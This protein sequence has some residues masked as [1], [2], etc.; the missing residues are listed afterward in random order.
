M[1]WAWEDSRTFLTSFEAD[2]EECNEVE[3]QKHR[4]E[5][6][7]QEREGP[8]TS[9]LPL[10][11]S[12]RAGSH[13]HLRFPEHTNPP[14]P[15]GTERKEVSHETPGRDRQQRRGEGVQDWRREVPVRRSRTAICLRCAR[16][17]RAGVFMALAWLKSAHL[18]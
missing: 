4:G 9:A 11:M 17:E 1:G 3:V 13:I 15:P 6:E 12:V 8:Q 5:R 18:A 16:T 2:T 10:M 7:G 14:R